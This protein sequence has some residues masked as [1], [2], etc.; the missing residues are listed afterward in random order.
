[1]VK[2]DPKNVKAAQALFNYYM[3]LNRFDDAEQ[4]LPQLAAANA[5]EADGKLYQ[6]LLAKGR[7]Q[8][9]LALELAKQLTRDKSQFTMS[10]VCL[11]QALQ[12]LGLYDQAIGQYS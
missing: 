5:D 4:Y 10:W 9:D 1:A 7:G 12:A 6:F 2:L 3:S 8:N 11:G